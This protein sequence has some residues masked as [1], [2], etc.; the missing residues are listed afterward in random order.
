MLTTI[1][2]GACSPAV[3]SNLPEFFQCKGGDTFIRVAV[4]IEFIH[5]ELTEY[6]LYIAQAPDGR[7]LARHNILQHLEFLNHDELLDRGIAIEE[8]L[9]G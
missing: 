4:P 3:R 6:W 5:T 9:N 7:I 8:M 1:I 2:V